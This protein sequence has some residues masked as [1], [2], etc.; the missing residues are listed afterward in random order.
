MV[1]LKGDGYGDC[2]D[3]LNCFSGLADLFVFA[4]LGSLRPQK[5]AGT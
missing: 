4:F 3:Y 1:P 5:Q 2:K